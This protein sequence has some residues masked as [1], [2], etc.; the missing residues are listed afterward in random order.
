MK[1]KIACNI[2]PALH[3]SMTG[4]GKTTYEITKRLA[5]D[6]GIFLEAFS[7]SDETEKKVFNL[8]PD[9]TRIELCRT[10]SS[11]LYQ[12]L[13]LFLPIPYRW[14]FKRQVDIRLFFNFRVPPGVNAKN[15]TVIYDM[16]LLAFPETM[17]LRTKILLQ[18][19]LRQSVRRVDRIFTIS[20]FS[21]R[22][23]VKYLDIVPEKIDVIPLGID[24]SI[25]NTN[26][27]NQTIE[28][29]LAK[30]NISSPY[31]LF[32]GTLEPRKNVD[33]ILDAYIDLY[34]C[35]P[36][37]PLLV[38]VGKKGW[39]YE[40]IFHK[41]QTSDLQDKVRFTGYVEE[42]EIPKFMNG[43]LAFLFPSL[44]EGFGL[45][46]LEAMACG[47]PVI[48]SNTSSLPEVVGNAGI[49]IDPYSVKELTAAMSRILNDTIFREELINLGKI[50]AQAFTW[51]KT[52]AAVYEGC[53][54]LMNTNI[55]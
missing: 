44:Y 49:L 18:L 13:W 39:N 55:L 54:R 40:N 25:Y 3:E 26:Y 12:L 22:E 43:A 20:E 14:F 51:E 28:S 21:K 2:Q 5:K 41:I 37:C 19:T 6:D 53:S 11:Q 1:I 32:V 24:H 16:V 48:V 50:R 35:E 36:A 9:S 42:V 8:C 17:S 23:I 4:I 29:T 34:R 31:F 46:P 27:S 52:V 15:A 47:T 38:I 30:H 7:R 10:L 33:L 45:P